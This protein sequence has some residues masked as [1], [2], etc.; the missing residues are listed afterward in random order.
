MKKCIKC[1]FELADDA[2][3]CSECGERQTLSKKCPKCGNIIEHDTMFCPEC[4]KKIHSIENDK[5]A[6]PPPAYEDK[7]STKSKNNNVS[8]Y[9]KITGGLVAVFII[10]IVFFSFSSDNTPST[11]SNTI[12]IKADEMLSEFMNNQANAE[13]KFKGK[14]IKISGQLIHKNQFKN[15]QDYLMI[16]AENNDSKYSY[17]IMLSVDSNNTKSVNS[18]KEGDFVLA[19]GTCVGIVPQENPNIITIQI[20]TDSINE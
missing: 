16:I 18:V 12:T 2:E 5:T 13:E 4:G 6:V 3:F 7:T 20:T 10:G 19:H 17:Y 8:K 14:D 9:F 15:S 11:S 1:N